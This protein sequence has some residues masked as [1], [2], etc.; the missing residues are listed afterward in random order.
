MS[1]SFIDILSPIFTLL[2]CANTKHTIVV[3][4]LRFMCCYENSKNIHRTMTQ[5][6][7]NI[8]KKQEKIISSTPIHTFQVVNTHT[9]SS[10]FFFIKQ[11]T[12]NLFFL[13]FVDC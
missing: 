7:Q 1:V 13:S 11:I 8:E 5:I 2:M 10:Y 9:I 6:L 4:F 3:L 12:E